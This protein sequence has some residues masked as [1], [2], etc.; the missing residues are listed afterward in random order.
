MFNYSACSYK[1]NSIICSNYWINSYFFNRKELQYLPYCPLECNSIQYETQIS[2]QSYPSREEYELFKKSINNKN[3]LDTS[4]YTAFKKYFFKINVFYNSM[5]YTFVTLSPKTTIVGL[6]SKLGGTIG[7][8]LGFT[9]FTFFEAL[10]MLIHIIYI[11][12]F[13]N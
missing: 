7:A 2:S 11:L 5:E 6:L 1:D 9:F 3:G 8:L 12:I 4:S 10:E 13:F